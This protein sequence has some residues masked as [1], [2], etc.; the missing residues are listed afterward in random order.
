MRDDG[1][2]GT[3]LANGCLQRGGRIYA[4]PNE[5]IEAI[6]RAAEGGVIRNYGWPSL[7]S[8]TRSALLIVGAIIGP[9]WLPSADATTDPSRASLTVR[10]VL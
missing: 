8:L 5:W 3:V 6:D 4:H 2:E 9:A 7:D 10:R 1:S